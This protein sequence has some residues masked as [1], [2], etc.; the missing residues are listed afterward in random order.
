[1]LAPGPFGEGG[2]LADLDGDGVQEFVGKEGT[3]LGKLTWRRPPDWKPV[4]IDDE[5]ETH[6]CMEATLFG[7]KG[8]LVIQRYM[9]V[10]FYERGRRKALA[11]PR[12][13]FDLHSVSADRPVASRYRWRWTGRYRMR[14]L[15]DQE[16][17]VVSSF[18][19]I[20]S[21]SIRTPNYRN[22]QCLRM[23]CRGT[24]LLVAQG[25]MPD[26]RVTLF[27]MPED[28]RQ[29]WKETRI[30]GKFHRVHALAV[31]N[32]L[33]SS[34]RTTAPLS[35]FFAVRKTFGQT[36]IAKGIDSVQIYGIRKME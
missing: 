7:R 32:G 17:G 12:N 36:E 11:L 20:F 21:R 29:L 28:P 9:Q 6:D 10:R 34:A 14:Q 25:H 18:P 35:R 3:G 27:T 33:L 24:G 2:C 15:L 19:G 22:R 13:L 8:V 5:F 4:L 30:E 31:W 23:H 16:P 1:M 26:A